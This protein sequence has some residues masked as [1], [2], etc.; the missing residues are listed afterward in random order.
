MGTMLK[1]GTLLSVIAIAL[2]ML[3]WPVRADACVLMYS[4]GDMNDDGANMFM[5]T[6]EIGADDSTD[7]GCH[8]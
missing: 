6:E 7:S 3:C 8:L 2:I 4:G 1:K 5:R